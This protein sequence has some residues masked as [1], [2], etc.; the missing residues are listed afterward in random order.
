MRKTTRTVVL[1]AFALLAGACATNKSKGGAVPEPTTTVRVE[2]QAFNDM[3]VYVV[4]QAGNRIRLGTVTGNSTQTLKIPRGIVF[5][6]TSLR[7]LVDPIGS[8]RTASSF[9]ITVAPGDEV[10][11]TIP[12]NA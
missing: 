9:D 10:K 5:G 11:L 12:P 6:P 2:N 3:T 4:Q 8:N 1:T 7:F